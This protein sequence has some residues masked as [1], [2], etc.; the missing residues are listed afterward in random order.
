MEPFIRDGRAEMGG[1]GEAHTR[2][3]GENSTTMPPVGSNYLRRE[4][5]RGAPCLAGF[6]SPMPQD[7][8]VEGKHHDRTPA[9]ATP[10][11]TL[12]ARRSRSRQKGT[13][14]SSW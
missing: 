3:E 2:L 13:A 4:A 6:S 11:A 8:D 12:S 14:G 5:S 1:V 9:V 10:T 7:V